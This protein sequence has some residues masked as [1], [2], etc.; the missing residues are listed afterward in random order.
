MLLNLSVSIYLDCHIA[1]G[2]DRL[3]ILGVSAG[4]LLRKLQFDGCC[5]V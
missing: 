3:S 5:R 1:R 4:E 2:G